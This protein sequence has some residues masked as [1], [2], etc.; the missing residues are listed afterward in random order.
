M[1]FLQ[2]IKIYNR[3]AVKNIQN[4]YL[5]MYIKNGTKMLKWHSKKIKK[6][7]MRGKM[8]EFVADYLK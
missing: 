5:N 1:F 2:N 8:Y 4:K 6:V 3:F 7:F